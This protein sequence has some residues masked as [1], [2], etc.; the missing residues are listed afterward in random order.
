MT[1]HDKNKKN[2]YITLIQRRKFCLQRG[3]KRK[4]KVLHVE[5]WNKMTKINQNII[6]NV[7]IYMR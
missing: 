1:T 2:I 6:M 4:Q 7:Y 5:I 3:E